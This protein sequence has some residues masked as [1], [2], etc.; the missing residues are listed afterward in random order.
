MLRRSGG[1]LKSL[2]A[3]TRL[4]SNRAKQQVR[5]R[6]TL[7]VPRRCRE[8]RAGCCERRTERRGAP[9][10]TIFCRTTP[11]GYYCGVIANQDG[12][13]IGFVAEL[14]TAK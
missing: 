12:R 4:R 9:L 11:R 3:T 14:S 5:R 1:S 8:C 6:R 10:D 7:R 2:V 13:G